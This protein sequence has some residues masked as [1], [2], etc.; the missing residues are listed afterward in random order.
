MSVAFLALAAGCGKPAGHALPEPPRVASCEPGKVGGQLVLTTE[1][2][3]KTFNPV[4]AVDAGSESVTRLLFS[5]LVHFDMATQEPSPGLAESW[6]VEAD[7]K[8]WTF[9]LRKGLRWSDGQP[10]TAD[11]VLFT[12]NDILYNSEFSRFTPDTLL[13]VAGKPFT[14]SKVDD[15]TIRLVT[16]EVVAPLLQFVSG[17]PIVPKHILARELRAKNFLNAYSVNVNPR[18][19]IGSGPYRILD[20]RAGKVI[21]LERNPEYYAVDK[22][23][24][25]LP[26][27]DQI[28]MNV[29]PDAGMSAFFFFQ[30]HWKIISIF[31]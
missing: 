20:S 30:N 29:A 23:G 28:Q 18:S 3:P 26:Y 12:W 13:S 9:K 19:I 22:N 25:R 24:V 2:S 7:Q 6:S 10:L 31:C 27:L 5:P 21:L 17:A 1:G 4:F 11:D 15:L 14:V 16:P 8:T